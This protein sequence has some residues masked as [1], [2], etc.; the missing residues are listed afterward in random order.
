MPISDSEEEQEATAHA[1]EENQL[2]LARLDGGQ[3]MSIADLARALGWFSPMAEPY[4]SKVQRA[5]KPAQGGRLH[6]ASARHEW[7]LTEK[8]ERL[9]RGLKEGGQ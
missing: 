9:A 7:D 4:K 2:L 8:G 5:L 6:E 3:A 1:E